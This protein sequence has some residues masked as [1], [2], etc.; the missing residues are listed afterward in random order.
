MADSTLLKFVERVV[1]VC[2]KGGC[3]N[4]ELF[5]KISLET[6]AT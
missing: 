3:V 4:S 5:N 1:C 2:G 6:L